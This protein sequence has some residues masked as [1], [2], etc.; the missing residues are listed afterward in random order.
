M[1]DFFARLR[2]PAPRPPTDLEREL[3]AA[4]DALRAAVA[5]RERAEAE[6]REQREWFRATLAGIADAVI[7]ADPTGRVTYVNPAAEELT[8]WPRAEATGQPVE[9]VF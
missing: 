5:G 3:A 1:F 7:V 2:A 6:L 4:N 8:G 9:K